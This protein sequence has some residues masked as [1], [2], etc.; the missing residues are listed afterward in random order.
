MR[1]GTGKTLINSGNHNCSFTELGGRNA[2]E[3]EI[4]D[5]LR[6]EVEKESV[7]L[8]VQAKYLPEEVILANYLNRGYGNAYDF[9]QKGRLEGIF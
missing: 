5:R 2:M 7:R 3:V 9:D 1:R 4:S 6:P 8:Q